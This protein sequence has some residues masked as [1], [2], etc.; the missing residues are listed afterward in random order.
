MDFWPN[1]AMSKQEASNR[2]SIPPEIEAEMTPAVKAF[3][4]AAFAQLP[5]LYLAFNQ[6]AT[7]AWAR[8]L[9]KVRDFRIRMSPQLW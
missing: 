9:L 5:V 6:L 4:L 8:E 3:V 7:N 1:A 2:I